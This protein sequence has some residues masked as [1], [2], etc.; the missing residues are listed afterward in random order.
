MVKSTYWREGLL[1]LVFL[2]QDVADIG[3]ATGLRGSSTANGL[4]LSAHTADPG[5]GGAQGTNEV[6]VGAWPSYARVTTS[7]GVSHWSRTNNFVFNVQTASFGANDGAS[8][9]TVTHIAAG[10]AGSNPNGALIYITQLT[11]PIVLAPG[12]TLQFI[13]NELVFT[14]R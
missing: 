8:A 5:I 9:V 10:V 6:T 13:P 7:R 4:F 14:E 2:N 3:D 11:S 1:D 12:V